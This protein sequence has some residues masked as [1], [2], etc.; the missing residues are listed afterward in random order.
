MFASPDR[1]AL[2]DWRFKAWEAPR[3]EGKPAA[4]EL[5]WWTCEV[6]KPGTPGP[7]FLHL[8]GL[9]KGHVW[10]NGHAAG[11][12]W[13]IGPQRTLNLPEPRW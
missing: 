11:R 7:H 8:N 5:V 9:H 12:Y 1:A 3:Q 2:A 4:G 10:L 6:Q 13:E